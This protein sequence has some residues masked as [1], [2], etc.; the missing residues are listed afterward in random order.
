MSTEPEDVTP[1]QTAP[2]ET[3][4]DAVSEA[5]ESIADQP[6]NDVESIDLAGDSSSLQAERDRYYEQW[7]RTQAEL[8]NFRKRAQREMETEVRY[9]DAGLIRDLLPALDNL[10]RSVQAA[11]QTGNVEELLQGLQMILSQF[12]QVLVGHSA[13]PIKTVGEPFDPNL[14]EALQEIPTSEHPPMTVLQEIE[15]GY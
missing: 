8:E 3:L 1:D 15:R 10:T 9:R 5:V 4:A 6:D 14:H 11:E 13:A 12:D 7:K 2:D